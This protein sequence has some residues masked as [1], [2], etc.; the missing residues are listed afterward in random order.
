MNMCYEYLFGEPLE[1]VT[2]ND[3][4]LLMCKVSM[5]ERCS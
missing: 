3:L 4:Y 5:G 2:I 1:L